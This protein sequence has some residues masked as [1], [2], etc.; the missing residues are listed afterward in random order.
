M[1]AAAHI[2]PACTRGVR[3]LPTSRRVL[4]FLS[5]NN[6]KNKE[7]IFFLS[8]FFCDVRC[9]QDCGRPQDSGRPRETRPISFSLM[10]V[11]YTSLSL[12]CAFILRSITTVSSSK[13]GRDT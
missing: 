13:M 11:Y 5:K 12:S 9:P 1:G 2:S 8:S 6:S 7:N 4:S 10:C 3:K